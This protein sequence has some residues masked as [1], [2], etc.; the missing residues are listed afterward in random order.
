MRKKYVRDIIS[1]WPTRRELADEIGAKVAAVHKWAAA[2]RIPSDWQYKV[3]QAANRRG[4]TEVTSE[5]ML[6]A[7]ADHDKGVA[8]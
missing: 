4:F 2:N 7:H 8:P 3:V 1:L 5:A 6:I